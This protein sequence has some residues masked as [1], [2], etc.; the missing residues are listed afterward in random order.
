MKA[1]QCDAYGSVSDPAV[2]LR[3]AENVQRPHLSSGKLNVSKSNKNLH[4]LMRMAAEKDWDT[5]MVVRTLAVALA[6]GDVRVMSGHTREFQGPPSWPYI[7]GGDVCGQVV[8]V[9]ANETY[10][11]VGDIVAARFTVAPR[12]G[13]AEYA[14]VS[15]TVCEKVQD[16]IS[17]VEAAALV[18]ASP[19]VAI[20]TYIRPTDRRVLVLGASGGIGSHF[21]QL[22]RHHCSSDNTFLCGVASSCDQLDCLTG[23]CDELIDYTQNNIFDLAKFQQDPFDT[24]FDF[25]CGGWPQLMEQQ[26][27][28]IPS[29]VKPA[30]QGGRYIT[31][32][33]DK[34]SFQGHSLFSLLSLFLLKPMWRFVWS[35]LFFLNRNRFPT[36]TY[37][38]GLPD[39]RE[40]VTDTL[41]LA[42]NGTLKAIVDGPYPMTTTGVREAFSKMESR[43]GRGKIVIQVAKDM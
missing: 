2:N 10:F 42:Y 6:P 4:P 35:R 5:H 17:P 34:P 20:S 21:C 26:K 40:V 15:T 37:A 19:A 24:I 41:Q 43:H 9:P 13:L 33:S 38:M 28:G 18:S 27:R 25:A 39:S 3:V 14:R 30:S 22:I 23:V 31:I 29:I 16:R 8:E 1:V 36:F 11:Q 12:Y 7:P 32:T